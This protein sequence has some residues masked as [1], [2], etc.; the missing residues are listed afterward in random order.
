M[1]YINQIES[2]ESDQLSKII[3]ENRAYNYNELKKDDQKFILKLIDKYDIMHRYKD[4]L[5]FIHYLKISDMI[6]KEYEYNFLIRIFK[7]GYIGFLL[8]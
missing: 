5:N 7:T 2:K 6:K 4:K 3:K 8:N 1:F